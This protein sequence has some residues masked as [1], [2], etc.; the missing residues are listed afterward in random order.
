MN[1]LEGFN[2]LITLKL[3]LLGTETTAEARNKEIT[4]VPKYFVGTRQFS[5]KN[6]VYQRMAI[7]S[8]LG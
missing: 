6:G 8:N 4:T 5:Q 1:I 2:I 7:W 3:S